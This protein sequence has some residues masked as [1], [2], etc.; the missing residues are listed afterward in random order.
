[1]G[2]ASSKKNIYKESEKSE[3]PNLKIKLDT[4]AAQL[5]LDTNNKEL[6]QLLEVTYC[7]KILKE[8]ENILDSNFTKIQLEVINGIITNKQTTLDLY[9]KLNTEDIAKSL[10]TIEE[11][12]ITK[13][14]ICKNIALFYTKITH[15]YASIYRV[16]GEKSVCAIKKKIHSTKTKNVES[17]E[18]NLVYVKSKHCYKNQIY[19]TNFLNDE[20]GIPELEELYKD[21]YD[22]NNKK[23][24]MSE[25]QKEIYQNDVNA[26]FKS[27]T[28]A[29]N[30]GSIKS[31]KDI[32]IFDYKL[33][34][35]NTQSNC[36]NTKNRN[37]NK[38]YVGTSN[39]NN[40]KKYANFISEIM[41]SA[42]STQIQLVNLLETVIFKKVNNK[43]IVNNTL[44]TEI[45]NDSIDITR[46]LIVKMFIECEE[47]YQK[48]VSLFKTIVFDKNISI[49][50]KRIKNISEN[51]ELL[52]NIDD[53]EEKEISNRKNNFTNY[54]I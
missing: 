42:N 50:E 45:L 19:K 28:G 39:N 22:E 2:N 6:I 33:N 11:S 23:F 26:F 51:K 10:K 7:N 5:I 13:K 54:F 35:K 47:K 12:H 24:I 3:E 48:A 41:N 16:I 43:Y 44:T 53:I 18:N 20:I 52:S 9:T 27:Y 36:D 40:I 8:T 30:D 25:K 37:S 17:S 31:F 49:S 32:P 1:M 4:I 46:Q 34:T 21:V 29:E 14:S 38:T 15:L